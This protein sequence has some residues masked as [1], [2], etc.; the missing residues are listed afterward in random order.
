MSLPRLIVAGTHSGSGKTTVLMGLAAALSRLGTSVQT[1][2]TGPD[3]IDP[4]Y[5]S[6]ASGRPCRN[7]D[8]R[9]LTQDAVLELIDRGTRG[10]D[11]TLIE[12][13]M[14]LF[15]G[16][17]G[18]DDRGSAAS[19]A[20]MSQTPV[21]L[22][23]DARAM[24]RS[25]AAVVHGFAT[26]DP[27]V[28]VAG[29]ILNRIGSPRHAEMITQAIDSA[30]STT[31]LGYIPREPLVAVP[32]RHLG[33]V[34]AWEQDDFAASLDRLVDLVERHIHLDALMALATDVPDLPPYTT[35]L[36][37][38]APKK[39]TVTVAVAMD[40]AFHFY[41]QDNLDL[42]EYQGARI[43]PFSPL[44]DSHLPQEADCLYLGGGYPELGAPELEANRCMRADILD[45]ARQGMP[46]YAECGGLMY[47]VDRIE[48]Q[49]GHEHSMVGFFPGRMTLGKKR[50]ALGYCDGQTLVDTILGPAGTRIKGHV[51][52]WSAYE[53]PPHQAALRLIKGDGVTE[54]GLATANVLASYLHIHFASD[55]SIPKRFL[56][57]ALSWRNTR[58][59]RN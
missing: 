33:L 11:L 40:R 52:H 3:Y 38:E 39:P 50:R 21:V 7:L 34:S 12:G 28:P 48:T 55:P 6:I 16:A 53:G 49:D 36:F 47:L 46:I 35:R 45:K 8:S 59:A 31:V 43:V 14:G 10:A 19:L 56:E 15:D 27:S 20:R 24:A 44:T 5:H 23:L 42:L 29:V 25:A 32:E 30:S 4:G 54:E 41:Y 57:A 2:K 17:S 22:V 18:L 37:A 51:F 13:V 58:A 1:F 9:L 26:F